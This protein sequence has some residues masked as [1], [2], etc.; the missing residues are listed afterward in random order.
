MKPRKTV[1]CALC[2]KEIPLSKA[3]A[4]L[5]DAEDKQAFACNDHFWHGHD[6]IIG[7]V[8]FGA[9]EQLRLL[10]RGESPETMIMTLGD[11]CVEERGGGWSI[12]RRTS[13]G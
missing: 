3:T 5:F 2:E 10:A 12:S 7:W 1:V 11:T 6:Y 4:G 13:E 8:D 9:S